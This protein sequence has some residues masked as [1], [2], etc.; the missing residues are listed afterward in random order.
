MISK[1][2]KLAEECGIAA[3]YV[4]EQ[5]ETR[6][7]PPATKRHL[8]AI[9][10]I[11]PDGSAP[12]GLAQALN[13]EPDPSRKCHVPDFL[14][15]GRCWG[16]TCQLYGLRSERNWGI[17]DFAD[18]ARLAEIVGAAGADFL[19]VNPLHALYP[20][21]PQRSSPYSPS[22]RRFLNVL[23]IAPDLEPEFDAARDLSSDLDTL[24]AT[25]LVDYGEVARV[26]LGALERMYRAFLDTGDGERR[27]RFELFRERKGEALERHSTFEALHEHFGSALWRE[28]PEESRSPDG[29]AIRRFRS[30]KAERI[31]FFAWLQWLA[32]RQ[33]ARAQ[34]HAM[35]AGMR[36]G[37][38]L[39]IAVGVPS[40]SAA[41]WADP[42]LMAE[43][44]RIGAPPDA[45]NAKGQ[46]WGLVPYRPTVLLQRDLEPF[47]A[48]LEAS[49]SHAGAV[50]LDHAMALQRLYWVPA[51]ATALDGGYVHYPFARM[52]SAVAAESRRWRSLVIGEALGTVPESY[53]RILGNAEVQS[54]RL[55]I[56]EKRRSGGFRRPGSY[57]RR[58]LGCITTH[59]LPTL[60]GWWRGRDIEWRHNIG[61]IGEADAEAERRTRAEE[62]Q[63][64]WQGLMAEGLLPKGPVPEHIGNDAVVA[65]HRYLAKSPVRLMGVQ[66]EDALGEV[67]Q[68]NLPGPSEPH[69]NWRRKLSRG[70]DELPRHELFRAVVRAMAELRPRA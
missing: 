18:L 5:G 63:W 4:S 24:R 38:Y 33:L 53:T 10:G 64:L 68:A 52:L 17:G 50:R 36:I 54:Y 69:P 44:A 46:D 32:N 39:D 16:M 58:A 60:A 31:G 15:R 19:G 12:G 70:L 14:R 57:P 6:H 37:L 9:L 11:D 8:L 61:F 49:M 42:G 35:A 13:T 1:L 67:E 65:A 26:K 41:V 21:D 62:R 29:E 55:L 45:F 59:D 48:D 47:R 23:Y 28:W 7:V 27:L 30:D 66:L 51:E 25:D 40:D 3:T 2:N 43:G 34:E 56:F 20:A 22:S